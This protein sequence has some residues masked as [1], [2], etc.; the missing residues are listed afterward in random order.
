MTPVVLLQGIRVLRVHFFDTESEARAFARSWMLGARA[1]HRLG[2]ARREP[3]AALPTLREVVTLD[4]RGWAELDERLVAAIEH[5][6]Q[7]D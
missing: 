4:G 2:Y 7:G 1:A 3:I 5:A 6:V